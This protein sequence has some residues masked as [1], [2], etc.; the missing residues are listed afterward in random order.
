MVQIHFSDRA[1]WKSVRQAWYLEVHE[2]VLHER[3]K[4]GWSEAGR[5]PA[6]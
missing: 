6:K 4:Q 1:L 3:A 5:S 2:N